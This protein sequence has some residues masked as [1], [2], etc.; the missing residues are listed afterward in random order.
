MRKLKTGPMEK[1]YLDMFSCVPVQSY[2]IESF[3]Q[4]VR[5]SIKGK[6]EA[7]ASAGFSM[8]KVKARLFAKAI[9][10]ECDKDEK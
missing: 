4:V 5:I 6:N 2:H 8:P 9:L 3:D 1:S 7:S 10:A